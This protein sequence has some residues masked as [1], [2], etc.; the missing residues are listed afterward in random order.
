MKLKGN[1]G[2]KLYDAPLN[3]IFLGLTYT[4][5]TNNV[6]ASPYSLLK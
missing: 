3:G 2:T 5:R 1:M 4:F 6:I